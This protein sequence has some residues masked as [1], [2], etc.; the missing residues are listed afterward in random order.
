MIT[1]KTYTP[2]DFARALVAG[3]YTF[4]G[5]YPCY[6]VTDD[7]AALSFQA[8]RENARRICQS[9]RNGD[10]DGWTV[11]GC[12]VNWEDEHLFCAHTGQRIES[13]YGN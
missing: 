7:G 8:A 3:P 4:P 6:F 2:S 11:I 1:Q 9:T 10:R 13:A 12:D 5:C